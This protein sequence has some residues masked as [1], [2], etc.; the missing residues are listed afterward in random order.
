MVV[1]HYGSVEDTRR[2]LDSLD[3]VRTSGLEVLV[4]DNSG[5]PATAGAIARNTVRV[6]EAGE[7]KG[8]AAGNDENLLLS[9]RLNLTLEQA[10]EFIDDD[11]LVEVTPH[12]IRLRKKQLLE[13]DRKRTSRSVSA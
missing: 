1:L 2:C 7:H 12:H 8:F 9:P 3:A 6:I 5:D 10:L 4:V 13:Q 11:E